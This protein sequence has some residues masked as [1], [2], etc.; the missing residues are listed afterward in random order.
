MALYY[1]K[2]CSTICILQIRQTWHCKSCYR[3]PSQN[4]FTNPFLTCNNY[5]FIVCIC[6]YLV[7]QYSSGDQ[8]TKTHTASRGNQWFTAFCSG[9]SSWGSL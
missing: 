6:V 3:P 4:Q 2:Y 5:Q 1:T 7:K 8:S 9:T